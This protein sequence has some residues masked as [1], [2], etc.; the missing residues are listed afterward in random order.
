VAK[1]P[2]GERPGADGEL[3]AVPGHEAEPDGERDDVNSKTEEGGGDGP[4]DRL[5]GQHPAAA[6]V[7]P[8]W[9][10]RP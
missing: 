8:G 10:E 1:A 9:A 3:V 5:R 7:R 4:G 6:R 2:V